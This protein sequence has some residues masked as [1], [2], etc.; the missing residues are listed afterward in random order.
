MSRSTTA[1]YLPI[2]AAAPSRW[3]DNFCLTATGTASGGSI[4]KQSAKKLRHLWAVSLIADGV[5]D[6]I[7]TM[8]AQKLTLKLNLYTPSRMRYILCPEMIYVLCPEMTVGPGT[9]YTI[10]TS[11]ELMWRYAC[12]WDVRG[13]LTLNSVALIHTSVTPITSRDLAWLTC[14]HASHIYAVPHIS[15][16]VTYVSCALQTLPFVSRN[17]G[18]AYWKIAPTDLSIYHQVTRL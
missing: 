9:H 5:Q 1:R 15:W 16:D 11:R 12:N 2:W 14:Q 6:N 17:G 13:D 10:I 7:P 3:H 8:S 18:N 4:G